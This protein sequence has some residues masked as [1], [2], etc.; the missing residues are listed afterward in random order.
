MF[1]IQ[2]IIICI[3]VVLASLYFP[4]QAYLCPVYGKRLKIGENL[5]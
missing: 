5:I 3:V 1:I 4:S 2:E